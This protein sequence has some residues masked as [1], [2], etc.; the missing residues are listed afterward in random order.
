MFL[1]VGG[2]VSRINLSVSYGTPSDLISQGYYKLHHAGTCSKIIDPMYL[3]GNDDSLHYGTHR[4]DNR[5]QVI[6]G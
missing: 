6:L 1:A 4:S 2:S 3:R 5:L